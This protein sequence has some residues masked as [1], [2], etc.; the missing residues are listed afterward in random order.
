MIDRIRSW[1]PP[2]AAEQRVVGGFFVGPARLL[3]AGLQGTVVYFRHSGF[4]DW[5][6]GSL[7]TGEDA[8]RPTRVLFLLVIA[9]ARAFT[10]WI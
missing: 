1:L 9:A 10:Q 4:W 7:R 3:L 5:R 2:G 8:W 6:R